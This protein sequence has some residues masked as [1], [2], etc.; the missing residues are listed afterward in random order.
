MNFTKTKKVVA[1]GLSALMMMTSTTS[2]FAAESGD[3]SANLNYQVSSSY[4]WIIHSSIDFG[5]DAGVGKTVDRTGNQVKVLKNVI[6][7]GKY[8][9]ISVK[10]SGAND[11]FTVDNGGSEVLNYDV[12]DDNGA[13][14]VNGNVLSVP[15]GT[16]TAT[17][18]MGFKLNTTKKSAEV[19]GQYNG[20]VIYNASV[21]DKNG[22]T[23]SGTVESFSAGDTLDIEGTKYVVLEQKENNQALVMTV[24]SIGYRKFQSSARADGQ[25]R[26]TYE[27]SEIDNYLENDWYNS[28]SSTM[29]SAIQPTSIKQASYTTSNDPDSKQETGTN[30]QVYNTIDRHAFLPSVSEIGKVVDLKNP[31]KVK[32][33]LNG[34]YLWTRDSYQG[35]ANDAE[36]LW[37]SYGSLNCG[38]VGSTYSVRPA[39]VIDL[40]QVNHSVVK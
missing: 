3:K 2:V 8:L 5:A 12:S 23:T 26:S 15:A 9:N 39:F 22:G 19:A 28:L 27:G 25:N 13:V 10:G 24:S 35:D 14:G 32:A 21:G 40:S 31:D 29:K 20:R 11:A 38:G 34:D 16:N 33:F 6:P 7:E 18:N 30:G 4:D 1:A 17:Q 36:Y 37:P